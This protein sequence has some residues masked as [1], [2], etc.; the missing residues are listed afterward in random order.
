MKLYK[1][2]QIFILFPLGL[3]MLRCWEY[4]V[5][6]SNKWADRPLNQTYK[7]PLPP[8]EKNLTIRSAACKI[9]RKN[10]KSNISCLNICSIPE[11]LVLQQ[12]MKHRHSHAKFQ[13]PAE[14]RLIKA[15][16]VES[17]ER[18]DEDFRCERRWTLHFLCVLFYFFVLLFLEGPN[19]PTRTERWGDMVTV[20]SKLY[21]NT[22]N[23]RH[24]DVFR[25]GSALSYLLLCCWSLPVN[26]LI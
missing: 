7:A 13:K 8:F 12:W 17:A 21:S 23:L 19:V 2:T 5:N 1:I 10:M 26:H 25:K 6:M 24:D 16:V 14:Q 20:S 15:S 18:S 9:R 3:W 4:C 22:A 11:G